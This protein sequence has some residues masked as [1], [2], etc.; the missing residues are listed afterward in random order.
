MCLLLRPHTDS[1]RPIGV[2]IE[3]VGSPLATER[4][5]SGATGARDDRSLI[6]DRADHRSL[7]R[8]SEANGVPPLA[9]F[10]Q[11]HDGRFW[12]KIPRAY[13]THVA[14]QATAPR[15]GTDEPIRPEPNLRY[16]VLDGL[17]PR[18]LATSGGSQRLGGRVRSDGA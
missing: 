2:G 9:T 12:V 10:P 18:S 1:N 14:D 11:Q 7:P 15:R 3:L 17:L 8:L 5:P 13:P 6:P 16:A 4:D